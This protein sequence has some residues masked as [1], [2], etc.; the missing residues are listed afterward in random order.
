VVT[1]VRLQTGTAASG[2]GGLPGARP[3]LVSDRVTSNRT[4]VSDV[5]GAALYDLSGL[6]SGS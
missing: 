5:G 3:D 4:L 6:A 2:C 1:L